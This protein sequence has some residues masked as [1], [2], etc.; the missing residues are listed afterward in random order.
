M[1]WL[2]CLLASVA[3]Y[4]E[5]TYNFT[6]QHMHVSDAC[7]VHVQQNSTTL[8]FHSTKRLV[9]IDRV[10]SVVAANQHCD[11]VVFGYPDDNRVVLWRNG[12]ET[13][14]SR[15]YDFVD[16][17][18]FDVDVQNQTWAVGAP[19]RPNDNMGQGAT[20]GYAFVYE[21]GHLHSCRSLYDSQCYMVGAECESGFVEWKRAQGLNNDTGVNEYQRQ[22]TQ[23]GY[24]RYQDYVLPPSNVGNFAAHQFGYSVALSGSLTG[25]GSTLYVSAPGDTH[26]FMETPKDNYGRVYAWDNVVWS[27]DIVW[28]EMNIKS[29]IRPPVDKEGFYRA[30]G[31]DVAASHFHLAVASYPLYS[32]P[33][34]PFI[35]VYDCH[36][37]VECV[38][39]LCDTPDMNTY[40]NCEP[41]SHVGI[42]V[43]DVQFPALFY[44]SARMKTY[45]DA[46]SARD[47]IAT[48]LNTKLGDFQNAL[49]GRQIGVAG[50]NVL[51][52]D[53]QNHHVY[54]MGVDAR[55]RE[56]YDYRGSVGY[57]TDTEQ[58]AYTFYD[59]TT[60]LWPCDRGDIGGRL[61]CTPV[62]R[63]YYSNDGWRHTSDLCPMNYTTAQMGQ[64]KCERWQSPPLVGLSW[65]ETL[66]IMF[67]IF[68]ITL[69]MYA[70]LVL[71]QRCRPSRHKRYETFI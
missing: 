6:A 46:W 68:G 64:R 37:D 11:L 28:W 22:C 62:Q 23:S 63:S 4:R 34:V 49:M 50:S 60:H 38:P 59:E 32:E 2:F 8:R 21:G 16:R 43:H 36:T 53:E 17:F 42:S 20:M 33:T 71:Y 14:I 66:N 67:A 47:Y 54:R 7:T 55:L 15:P 10:S 30:F 41:S 48:D 25:P 9:T 5:E 44:Y 19:G 70:A 24:P 69:G 27:S 39:G 57:G 3:A 65:T 52:T 12:T 56:Q 26:K 18:G 45:T 13:H 31:R 58:W 1:L 35:F 61:V 40:S 51:I 29:P